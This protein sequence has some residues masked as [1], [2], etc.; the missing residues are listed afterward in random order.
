MQPNGALGAT[1]LNIVVRAAGPLTEAQ[2]SGDGPLAWTAQ[3]THCLKKVTGS[4]RWRTF[5]SPCPANQL[6]EQGLT[7]ETRT[8]A[9]HRVARGW[10][11][12][13]LA[14]TA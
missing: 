4:L 5:L 14:I 13:G 3:C 7:A 1:G 11:C 12:A 2:A 10:R 8:H 6:E 9:L